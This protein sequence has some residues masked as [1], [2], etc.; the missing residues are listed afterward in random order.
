MD[1]SKGLVEKPCLKNE[2]LKKDDFVMVI[3]E[4]QEK[5]CFGIVMD[6]PSKHSVQVK[7]LQKKTIGDNTEYTH[8]IET[9]STKQVV[10]IYRKQ[11]K[12]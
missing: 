10:L 3:F 6:I 12:K 2:S 7:I 1:H 8:K 9:F 4:T 11:N 5:C